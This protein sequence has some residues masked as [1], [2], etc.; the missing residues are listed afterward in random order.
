[1]YEDNPQR[2]ALT[3][4]KEWYFGDTSYGRPILGPVENIQSFTQEQLFE[5][6]NN[7]YTKDNLVIIISGKIDKEKEVLTLLGDLF[8]SLPE[9]KK[10]AM[11]VYQPHTP[12]EKQASYKKDT[13]QNHII[14]S[15]R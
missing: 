14:V 10:V 15:C 1:M 9:K 12:S 2:K 3:K 13:E 4:R 5:H 11:P 8:G 7:L 6:K